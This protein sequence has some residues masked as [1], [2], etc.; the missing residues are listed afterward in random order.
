LYLRVG[1][2]VNQ[3]NEIFDGRLYSC[4]DIRVPICYHMCMHSKPFHPNSRCPAMVEAGIKDPNSQEGIN[5]CLNCPYDHCVIADPQVDNK[6]VRRALLIRA[7]KELSRRGLSD[8]EIA[9]ELEITVTSVK[10]IRR[11]K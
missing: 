9:D 5:F 4:I 11:R 3:Y 8:E 6:Q 1:I 10:R 2:R 7:V